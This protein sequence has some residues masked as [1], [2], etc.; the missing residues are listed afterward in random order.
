M[1]KFLLVV[2]HIVQWIA[3]VF[4]ILFAIVAFTSGGVAGGIILLIAALIVSPLIEK[5]P[6]ADLKIPKLL[7]IQWVA[8]FVLFVAGVIVTP[9]DK[10]NKKTTEE[11][12]I[13]QEETIA[14]ETEELTTEPQTEQP[15]TKET[16]EPVTETTTTEIST[17]PSITTTHEKDI[18]IVMRRNHPTYYGSVKKSHNIWNDVAEGKIH[19]ADE[20]Y[21]HND[22]S[23]LSMSAYRNSDIIREII[24]NF[25]NFDNKS[26]TIEKAIEIA[27]SYT[28]FEI[29]EQYYK[30]SL[31]EMIVPDNADENKSTYYTISY[32]LT[33]DGKK[34]EQDYSGSIDIIIETNGD[35]AK[36]III[37][38]GKPRWMSSL[39][40][41]KYHTE[42]W[43]CDL[44]MIETNT[45]TMGT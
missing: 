24:I 29:I 39:S 37:T 13:T 9:T 22:K 43:T 38:F 27:A 23:I 17:E 41:N 36:N 32:S 28:P 34:A 14:S 42:D 44:R 7:A 45:K 20:I 25:N 10:N 35:V 31:S 4:C 30:F 8:A 3:A 1:K 2:S 15:T 11:S 18:D 19:F 6:V 26:V 16:T 40:L 12:S 21:G 5:T 33:D